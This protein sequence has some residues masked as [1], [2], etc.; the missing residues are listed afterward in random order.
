MTDSLTLRLT[1]GKKWPTDRT[2]TVKTTTAVFTIGLVVKVLVND[3][4][5]Q[6][7]AKANDQN[8]TF[9]PYWVRSA[10]TSMPLLT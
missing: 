9:T 2:V 10:I 7:T 4:Y 8:L 6:A 3:L 1:N 5:V